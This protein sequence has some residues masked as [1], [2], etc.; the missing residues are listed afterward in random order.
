[1]KEKSAETVHFKYSKFQKGYNSYKNWSKS[2]TLQLALR[3]IKI[4][5]YTKFQHNM[6]KACRRKV[7]K[8]VYFQDSKF[9]RGIIIITPTKNCWKLM[10]LELDLKFIKWKS[11]AKSQ[12]NMPKHVGEK[13]GK[14]CIYSILSSKRGKT[15]TKIDANCWHICKISD[16][17]VKACRRKV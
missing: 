11:Y 12:L 3:L 4:R 9:Q 16:Q 8:T 1:M 17:Y 13:C 6:S 10:T 2:T 7:Q 15:P 5:S 14:L